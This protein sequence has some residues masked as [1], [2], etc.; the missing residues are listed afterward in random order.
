MALEGNELFVLLSTSKNMAKVNLE[1]P[2]GQD[3]NVDWM[4]G[5]LNIGWTENEFI[6]ESVVTLMEKSRYVHIFSFMSLSW[7]SALSNLW[8]MDMNF[9]GT[10]HILKDKI[11][12][13]L[14]NLEWETKFNSNFI[15]IENRT[16]NTW[17]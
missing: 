5:I 3:K 7:K 16:P 8:M 6:N 17:V 1:K 13:G 4:T 9:E 10:A 11:R 15:K 12:K 2:G 14:N